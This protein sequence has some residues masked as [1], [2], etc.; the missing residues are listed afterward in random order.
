M[1]RGFTLLEIMCAVVLVGVVTAISIATFNAVS[2]GW[3]ISTDYIDKMQRTDYALNQLVSDLRSLYYPHD[4]ETSY[5]YG[6][7]LNNNGDGEDPKSSDTIEF[8]RLAS[9]GDKQKAASTVHRVQVMILEEGNN[10]Y[11][12]R[13]SRAGIAKT[14]LYKRISP[15][16]SILPS[17]NIDDDYT[18]A[19]SE[20]YEPILVADGISGFNCRVLKE[21]PLQSGTKASYE[22][23][24][25]EDE[26][27][28]SNSVPCMV[29]LTFRIADPDGKSYRSNTAPVMRIVRLPIFEQSQDG[30]NT[31]ADSESGAENGKTD[32]RRRK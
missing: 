30:S 15:D 11:G 12:A 20:L 3:E 9:I 5:N 21:E 2:R 6:F 26:W 13:R 32:G 7:V 1:K 4:G 10:D 22:K 8:S 28:S 19:N 25:F 16:S 14:G 27:A 24:D 17:D 23:D 29:E 18:L 31:P